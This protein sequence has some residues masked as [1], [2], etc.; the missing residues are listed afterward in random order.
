M[1]P[2][3]L[4]LKNVGPFKNESLDFTQLENMFLI[5]GS[6]GAGKTTL[7]DAITYAL[8]GV[9]N[10]NRKGAVR[11]FRSNYVPATEE[12]FVE[13]TFT[14]TGKTYKVLRTLPCTYIKRDGTTGEHSANVSF[15]VKEGNSF[16]TYNCGTDE[17]NEKIAAVIGLNASEF[18]RIILLPQGEFAQ[19]LSENSKDRRSTLLKL[20]PVSSYT[21]FMNDVKSMADENSKKLAALTAQIAGNAEKFDAAEAEQRTAELTKQQTELET[22]QQKQT[23]RLASLSSENGKISALYEKALEDEKNKTRYDALLKQ[24]DEIILLQKKTELSQAA[25]KL[26]EHI[27]NAKKDAEECARIQSEKEKAE[28]ENA[29]AED[30]F[31]SFS[32]QTDKMQK[33]FADAEE[34]S[35]LLP[36]KKQQLSD[37]AILHSLEKTT[38]EKVQNLI[39]A[40]RQKEKA[41]IESHKILSAITAYYTGSE[42]NVSPSQVLE[43]ISSENSSAKLALSKSE[44]VLESAEKHNTLEKE[45]N[46]AKQ[47]YNESDTD[48]RTAAAQLEN[49]KKICADDERLLELSRQNNAACYLVTSLTDGKP[50]PVC[51]SLI[52]PSPALKIADTLDIETKTET[53]KK[54]LELAQNDYSAKLQSK[55]AA[56]KSLEEKQKLFEADKDILALADAVSLHNNAEKKAEDTET[57]YMKISELVKQFEKQQETGRMLTEKY[58]EAQSDAQSAKAAQLQAEKAAAGKDGALPDESALSKE[59]ALLDAQVKAGK[60]A[61]EKWNKELSDASRRQAESKTRFT[62]LTKQLETTQK[63]ATASEKNLLEALSVSPFKTAGE[64]ET[65]LLSSGDFD[66]AQKTIRNWQDETQKLSTLIESSK[67]ME[68]C[69]TLNCRLTEVTSEIEKS[70]KILKTLRIQ[71]SDIAS[72]KAKLT[73]C[74]TTAAKLS[75]QRDELE[76]QSKPIATLHE[77]ISGNNNAHLTFDTWALGMYFSTVVENAGRRF[78][79]LSNGRYTFKIEE[80][81]Q[82][83]NSY[84]GL[85]LLVTDS[86]TGTERDTATLSGGEM[87]MASISL[88]LALTD[89]VQSRNGGLELDSLFID[90]GFGSLDEESLDCAMDILQTLQETKTVGIIS[91]VESMQ[92]AIPS[93]VKI[94]KTPEGSRIITR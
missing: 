72:E 21:Q 38:A 50:C 53:D 37:I 61:Y 24:K 76:R 74:I 57:T 23:D 43:F 42:Q 12:S 16:T 44:K 5:S 47:F 18:S 71:I 70:D 85:D 10:G 84:R 51:G 41:E 58:S 60:S 54:S 49:I 2:L 17:T 82:G 93:H 40:E 6:T 66:N 65:A 27:R 73:D 25:E 90:E 4:V 87:F 8:Y 62:E 69:E 59:I 86:F 52:H 1:K 80:N 19:F 94:I 68:N 30:T 67:K 89:V 35:A 22:E 20:F 56:Q 45:I 88:A 79:T 7:F 11:E 26:G 29:S 75:E 36:Y 81:A 28:N 34:K 3:L 64:A 13:F 31:I 39:N 33:T 9:L 91:H 15:S 83:G 77:D 78:F 14:C 92:T 55:A 32:V 46:T 63:K 48:C